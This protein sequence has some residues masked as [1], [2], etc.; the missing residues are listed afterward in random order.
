MCELKIFQVCHSD[1]AMR[2]LQRPRDLCNLE[3]VK[4]SRTKPTFGVVYFLL[5]LLL[6]ARLLPLG[7]RAHP[8]LPLQLL[9]LGLLLLG[10]LLRLRLLALR[11]RLPPL[12]HQLQSLQ[13]RSRLVRLALRVQLLV[14]LLRLL[15]LQGLALPSAQRLVRLAVGGLRGR[16]RGGC[17]SGSS[18]SYGCGGFLAVVRVGRRLFVRI[19]VVGVGWQ[20]ARLGA[21]ALLGDGGGLAGFGGVAALFAGELLLGLVVRVGVFVVVVFFGRGLFLAGLFGYFLRTDL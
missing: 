21:T 4:H 6:G 3:T 10:P 1:D 7:R 16:R 12:P 5:R 20:V 17:G 18:G 2:G 8:V 15:R 19:L 9:R 11:L 13:I 14:S